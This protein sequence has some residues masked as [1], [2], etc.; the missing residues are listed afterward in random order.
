MSNR[1]LILLSLL[2]ALGGFA[3]IAVHAACNTECENISAYWTG[4]MAGRC[5]AFAEAKCVTFACYVNNGDVH[6]RRRWRDQQV[7]LW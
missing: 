4:S 1:L 5:V 3:D 2:L 7:R 6:G